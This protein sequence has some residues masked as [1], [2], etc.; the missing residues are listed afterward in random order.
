MTRRAIQWLV[1]VLLLSIAYAGAAQQTFPGFDRNNYPGD[2]TL[3]ALRR[4]F[5]YT[6]YWLNN[7]PGESANGWTG[8][9]AL[10][11]HYGFGFLVLFNG[12]TDAELQR[13][14]AAALGTADGK[15]AVAAALREG[16]ARR[17][18][19]FL[20]QEEG[21]RLLGKQ[22]AYIFA[23]IDAVRA[24]GARAGV[25]CSGIEVRDES[26]PISTAADIAQRETAREQKNAQHD[27]A[28]LAL[29]IAN[30]ACPPA[31]GCTL[32]TP[33]MRNAFPKDVRRY[34]TVWQYAQSPRRKEF[35]ASCPRN[36][37]PDGNCYAPGLPR[38]ADSFVD[39]DA[40]NSA[41]PSD[42]R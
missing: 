30:D 19:I 6:S 41:D 34:A 25:Y 7:P 23:W 33:S 8:K 21:G 1:P 26:G 12:R 42:D 22:A 5:R 31:P 27:E 15:A 37:A 40:A 14:D 17:V 36:V 16:F 28:R 29:W 2:A 18:R 10:L 4:S 3:P 24:A 20:D 39:L 11:K 13:A 32:Q 9:R 38:G 35:S